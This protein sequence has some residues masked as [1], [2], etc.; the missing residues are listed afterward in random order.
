MRE[1]LNFYI[2]I[3]SVLWNFY[4]IDRMLQLANQKFKH[5]I[6]RFGSRFV[7]SINK[8]L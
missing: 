1:K 2:F 6:L 4:M 5:N 3:S 8:V 7:T